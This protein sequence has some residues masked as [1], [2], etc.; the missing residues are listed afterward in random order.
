MHA[1]Q[2]FAHGRA[3][4]EQG[5]LAQ[6]RE[7]YQHVLELAPGH[8]GALHLLG[9]IAFQL[10]EPVRAVELISQSIKIDPNVAAAHNNLG[11]ALF[12]LGG[13]A[14]ALDSY[15]RSIALQPEDPIA[16]NN[17]GRALAALNQPHD[18]LVSYERAIALDGAYAEAYNNRGNS[19][20]GLAQYPEALADIDHAILLKPK[21]VGAHVNRGHVL[22]DQGRHLAAVSS[23]DQ[24]IELDPAFPAAHLGRGVSLAQSRNYAASL[25]SFDRAIALQPD[26][27][28]AYNA[29]GNLG[30]AIRNVSGALNDYAQAIEL[31][32][33]RADLHYNRGAVFEDLKDYGRA[34][35]SYDHAL[36]LDPAYPYLLGTRLYAQR[37]L[38]DWGDA[39]RQIEEILVGI[40]HNERVVT[41]FT[42][43]TLL[44][45][46]AAQH[47]AAQIWVEDHHPSRYDLP[48]LRPGQRSGRI[49]IGYFSADF[50]DHAT[51]YLL[52]ELF[53]KHDRHRFELTGFSFGPDPDDAMRRRVSAAFDR[54]VDVRAKSDLDIALLARGLGI[55]IAV[56]LKGF[57]AD[58][59][60]GVFANRAAPVQVSYLGYP[61]TMGA[62]YMDYLI[63]DSMVI[64]ASA[65]QHYAEKIVYLPNSYQPNDS[66]R[67][68]AARHFS[69][70]ELHLPD[71]GF[72]FCCFNNNYKITSD[73]FAGWVRILE[74]VSASVLWLLEDNPRAA[75]NLRQE[76]GRQGLDPRRLV[77]APRMALAEHL[78]RHRAANLFLDTLPCNAHTTASDALWTGLPVLTCIGQTFAGRVAASLLMAIDLPELITSTPE[79]YEA[80]AAELAT[81]PGRL[82][83]IAEKLA[84]NKRAAPLFDT[85][86]IT[87]HIEDAY[88]QMYERDL[89]ALPPADLFV[90]AG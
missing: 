28:D 84:R 16:Y 31:R 49:R 2:Q 88:T 56:D 13:Y 62:E 47:Q 77:F 18:A 39:D 33:E 70:A 36:V 46:P 66:H 37:H 72:V 24:A 90:K 5:H 52:A 85:P 32:P 65:R 41:P 63:A 12:D 42:A 34:L 38:C 53:E 26:N 9:L 74:R 59:R 50:H 75:K 40:R 86:L 1:Q 14:A 80:L 20:R 54:F 89:A 25:Q 8:P 19:L 11:N 78:A 61:G 15:G 51:C 21:F 79:E 43:A 30:R 27:A 7:S 68:I 82:H 44:D 81:D 87:K 71:S 60:A 6:A 17:R 3:C 45:S 58:H 69:R 4:H 29:R 57:T 67:Q 48:P 64:P 35:S 76:A 83:R 10:N 23:Y 55:D 73:T 22:Q